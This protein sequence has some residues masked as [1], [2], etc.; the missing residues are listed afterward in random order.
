MNLKY[1]IVHVGN[2][3][4]FW[5]T[6]LSNRKARQLLNKFNKISA[7]LQELLHNIIKTSYWVYL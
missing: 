3:S 5:K 4:F 6:Q 7:I 2:I 1:P